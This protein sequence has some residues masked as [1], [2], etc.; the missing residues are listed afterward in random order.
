MKSTIFFVIL[1]VIMLFVV[2][3][4]LRSR[5][6]R[7]RYA[8]LW[9]LV[10]LFMLVLV[11]FPVLLDR[12]AHLVGIT[13]PSNLLFILAIAMLLG[14]TLQLTLEV[15]RAEDRSRVLA[16]NV[17]ILNLEMREA[18]LTHLP[19]HGAPGDEMSDTTDD[20][21]EGPDASR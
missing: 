17:A 8:V 11:A 20:G 12:L 7:E 19:T 6:I 14:I 2:G 5:R 9:V 10:G 21:P 13:V 15:S 4:L 18:G 3:N 16:E 1:T